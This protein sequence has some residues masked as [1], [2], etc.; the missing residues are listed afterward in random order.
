M[1][2]LTKS[3]NTRFNV[4]KPDFPYVIGKRLHVR[5]HVPPPPMKSD[6]H[7]G[8]HAARERESI[9]PVQRCLLHPPLTGVFTSGVAELE[10][11]RLTRAGIRIMR[12][13][14]LFEL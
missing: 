14:L 2:T 12:S 6:C 10:I 8:F 9:D 5:F 3:Y 4:P 11:V 7:L 13:Y 1:I